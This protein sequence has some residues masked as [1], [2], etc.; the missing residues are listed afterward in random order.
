[1]TEASSSSLTA[2]RS[3]YVTESRPWCRGCDLFTVA[4]YSRFRV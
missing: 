2:S 3:L 4:V 1:L